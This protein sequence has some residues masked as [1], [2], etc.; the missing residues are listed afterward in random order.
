MKLKALFGAAV[1]ACLSAGTASAANLIV[2]GSGILLGADGVNVGGTLYDVRFQDGTCAALF[3]GCDEVSDFPFQSEPSAGVAAQ[4]LLDQVLI[5]GPAGNFDTVNTLVTGCTASSGSGVCFYLVPF[6][7]PSAARVD[8]RSALNYPFPSSFTDGV[9]FAGSIAINSILSAAP[10][11][12]IWAVFSPAGVTAPVP[13]P[14]AL[15]LMPTGL[16][17]IAWA[18]RRKGAPA[19][20]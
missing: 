7:I 13:V 2:N 15:L 12:R 8:A 5:D 9:G 17:A 3:S 10:P 14:G 11:E 6:A 16:A 20:A 1:A 4:A 18:N 19:K